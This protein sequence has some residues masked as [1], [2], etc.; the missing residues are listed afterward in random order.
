MQ[1]SPY[2]LSIAQICGT[3]CRTGS[4]GGGV[5]FATGYGWVQPDG[6]TCGRDWLSS[7]PTTQVHYADAVG[8]GGGAVVVI[9]NGTCSVSD[10]VC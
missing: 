9:D 7:H 3:G 6:T 10:I 8:G 1:Q 5:T 4:G 2:Q